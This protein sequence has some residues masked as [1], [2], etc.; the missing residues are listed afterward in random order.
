MTWAPTR[1][2]MS[3]FSAGMRPALLSRFVKTRDL[4]WRFWNRYCVCCCC[5][6][7]PSEANWIVS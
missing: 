4:F 7:V 6:V 3:S 2:T 5:C 1:F